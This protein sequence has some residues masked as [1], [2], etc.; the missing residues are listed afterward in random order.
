MRVIG[1]VDYTNSKIWIST[2][3]GETFIDVT[4][5]MDVAN[6]ITLS[7]SW[8]ITMSPD[9][10]YLILWLYNT[11]SDVYVYQINGNSVS[12]LTII[13]ENLFPDGRVAWLTMSNNKILLN[14]FSG[15]YLLVQLGLLTHCY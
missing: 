5:D 12:K 6:D 15:K 1:I 14:S 11:T 7:S 2:D 8:Y 10:C 4:T 13:N 3:F 9:G